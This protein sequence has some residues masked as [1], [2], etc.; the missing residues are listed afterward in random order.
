MVMV[1]NALNK[2]AEQDL[3]DEADEMSTNV[4]YTCY[5]CMFHDDHVHTR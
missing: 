4:C 3:N 2:Q 1:A 5:L